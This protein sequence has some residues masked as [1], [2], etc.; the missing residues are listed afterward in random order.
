MP[1][2][3]YIQVRA[4]ASNAWIPIKDAAI[5]ITD[6]SGAAIA[7]RLSNRNGLLDTPVAVDTPDLPASQTPNTDIIPFSVVNL[8]ARAENFEAVEIKNIQVF[9]DTVSV[10]NLE[11]I[12]L[13]AL[14]E[15]WN[16][17]EVFDIPPQNL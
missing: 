3:G 7:M 14:P 16:A 15:S 12:P 5:T 9:A 4:F 11:M 17:V 2:T 1:S 13:S 6:V 10:Q 8:Y